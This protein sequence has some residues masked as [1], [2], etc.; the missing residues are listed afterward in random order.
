MGFRVSRVR[1]SALRPYPW[2]AAVLA[3][4]LSLSAPAPV[5]AQ[6][7]WDT[8]RLIGPE[9]PRGLGVY[10]MRAGALPED[11]D[12]VFGTWTLPGFDGALAIRGGGGRG[13]GGEVAGFGGLDARAPLARHTEGQ[14]LD[15][16]WTG[17]LGVGVGEYVLVSVPVGVSAGRSWSSGSVWLAPYVYLGLALD[18]RAGDAAPDDEFDVQGSAGIGLDLALDRARR[19]V[20]R[21]SAALAD[22]QAVA[23]GLAIA[24]G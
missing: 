14:P 19:F 15:L 7:V 10:W 24:G 8:P 23:V 4:G 12:A 3:I 6:L 1:R 9:S 11:G 13:A 16:E 5:T 17:G 22:R 20:I 21:A 2:G 18:Y